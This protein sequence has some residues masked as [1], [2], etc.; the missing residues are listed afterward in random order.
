VIGIK[1]GTIC[2]ARQAH[3]IG[4]FVNVTRGEIGFSIDGEFHGIAFT[5][6]ELKD[7]PFYPAVSLREGG[8]ASFGKVIR[9]PDEF[10]MK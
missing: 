2:K 6:D 1:Y 7:G 10:L 3:K 8:V 4:V 9:N 5:G